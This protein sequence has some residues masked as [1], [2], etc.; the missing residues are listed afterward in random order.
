[1]DDR[2]Q[3][4]VAWRGAARTTCHTCC[5]P[6]IPIHGRLSPCSPSTPSALV[7]T[8][9]TRC[10]AFVHCFRG[11][12]RLCSDRLSAHGAP[13]QTLGPPEKR[14]PSETHRKTCSNVRIRV[15]SEYPG[16]RVGRS[17]DAET[18]TDRRGRVV[19][20]VGDA[21]GGPDVP[22]DSSGWS[23]HPGRDPPARRSS[24]SRARRVGFQQRTRFM[25][26]ESFTVDCPGCRLVR[27]TR[28]ASDAEPDA[29]EGDTHG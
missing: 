6:R 2:Q 5:H 1:M 4:I 14:G 18:C 24:R 29:G 17:S 13:S 20:P 11:L 25:K 21:A 7:C 16:A 9:D 12:L 15:W 23:S 8:R 10:K 3:Y 26:N 22:M 28:R 19:C 27:H